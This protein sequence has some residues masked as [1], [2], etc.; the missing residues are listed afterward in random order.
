LLPCAG[1]GKV[2]TIAARPN[3][4]GGVPVALEQWRMVMKQRI[5]AAA[6]AAFTLA[7]PLAAVPLTAGAAEPVQVAQ[8]KPAALDPATAAKLDAA[9]AAPHRTDAHKARDQYRHP[10]ETLSFFGLREDMTVVE[11]S[12]GSGFYSELLGPVLAEKGRYI[13]AH[14]SLNSSTGGRKGLANFLNKLAETPDAYGKVVVSGFSLREGA[15]PYAEPAS[16]DML[17]TFRNVHNWMGGDVAAKAFAS[18]FTVLKPGGILGVV[19]HRWPADKP[20]DP[21]A[22]NGYVQ[23]AVVKELAKAAGFVFVGASEVNANP[24]DTKDYPKGVWTL[25]PILTEGD[26]DRDRYLAIG[27]SDRMTLKFMKPK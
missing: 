15:P 8:T 24:K 17:L 27:E 25:P 7:L 14:N 26:K 9:L 2:A 4:A 13:A 21:K 18:F 1:S 16:A 6:L 12:P 22:A 19:E 11:I 3:S 20:Q 10:K 23:E 5:R